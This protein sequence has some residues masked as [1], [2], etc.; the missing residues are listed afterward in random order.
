MLNN[1]PIRNNLPQR[2]SPL[3]AF[4]DESPLL[5]EPRCDSFLLIQQHFDLM[6]RGS[7]RQSMAVDFWGFKGKGLDIVWQLLA[8]G[9]SPDMPA[10]CVK[11]FAQAT[12]LKLQWE[13]STV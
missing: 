6:T 5:L 12:F 10:A 3:T 1:L 4:A 8:A 13:K 11:T 9:V 2:A 7:M